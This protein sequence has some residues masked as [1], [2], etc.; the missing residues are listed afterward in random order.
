[1]SS[2]VDE[3]VKWLGQT[4]LKSF[5]RGTSTPSPWFPAYKATKDGGDDVAMYSALVKPDLV[6]TLLEEGSGWDVTIGRGRPGLVYSSGVDGE[7]S[8]Y[9]PSGYGRGIEVLAVYRSF[10]GMRPAFLEL[11]EEFRLFHNL[12]PVPTKSKFVFID[13]NGDESDAVRYDGARLLEIRTDLVAEYCAA[14]QMA[15]AIYVEAV[16]YRPEKLSELPIAGGEQTEVGTLHRFAHCVGSTVLDRPTRT[17]ARLVGKRFVLPGP[18]PNDWNEREGESFPDFVIGED[19]QGRPIRHTSDHRQLANNFGANQGAPHYLTPV[20]FSRDVLTKYFADPEKYAVEDG[21]IG[22]GGA[23]SL[24]IDN[25]HSDYVSVWLG[26]LG[27]DLSESE[28]YYWLSFNISPAGRSISATAYGR[29]IRAEFV[30]PQQPDLVFKHEYEGLN[31]DFEAKYQWPFFLP[32]HDDDAH[33][34]DGLR[35][36]AKD[37]RA[38]FDSQVQALTKLLVD[39]LNER[40]IAKGQSLGADA[41]GITKLEEFCGIRGLTGHDVHIKFLRML[42]ELR[43][44]GAAHRKGRKYDKIVSNLGVPSEGQKAVFERLLVQGVAFIR[45]LRESLID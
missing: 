21:L 13:D 23:W 8:A 38:E 1:M 31:R 37:N 9:E 41:R 45:F 33:V 35:M 25:D 39:S 20:F 18:R 16:R 17:L 14:K 7:T 26:D 19:A 22:C 2:Q 28:R 36:L 32:L 5:L 42:Q 30:D 10:D 29:Q 6:P 4:D 3:A 11:S 40:E 27:R 12:Y 24:R 34:L 43:S 15:L 44:S